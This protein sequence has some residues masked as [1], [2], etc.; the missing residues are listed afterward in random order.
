VLSPQLS[1]FCIY[2]VVYLTTLRPIPAFF[3]CS[4]S[5]CPDHQES[6]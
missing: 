3:Y 4:F 6:N 2:K 5:S 1:D